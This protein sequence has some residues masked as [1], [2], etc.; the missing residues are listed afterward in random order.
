[1]EQSVFLC[2]FQL[3]LNESIFTQ[4]IEQKIINVFIITVIHKR[5]YVS[6]VFLEQELV[7]SAVSIRT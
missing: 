6:F 4:I 5:A 3:K 1:M 7:L 2:N